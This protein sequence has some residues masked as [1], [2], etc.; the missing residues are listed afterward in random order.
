MI[1]VP[2]TP[3]STEGA[4][5]SDPLK[6]RLKRGL[7]RFIEYKPGGPRSK[8]TKWEMFFALLLVLGVLTFA[9][10][11]VLLGVVRAK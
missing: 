7:L 1:R 3:V 11:L 5:M 4:S 10:S 2:G 9:T 8:L 6:D